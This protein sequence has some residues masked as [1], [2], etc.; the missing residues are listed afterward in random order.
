MSQIKNP[1][2]ASSRNGSHTFMIANISKTSKIKPNLR[3]KGDDTTEKQKQANHPSKI[4]PF[5]LNDDLFL[6][7][8][9]KKNEIL[10]KYQSEAG[11]EIKDFAIENAHEETSQLRHSSEK[12]STHSGEKS[13]E[14][15]SKLTDTSGIKTQTKNMPSSL[16]EFEEKIEKAVFLS[17]TPCQVVFENRSYF[18]QS[19][20]RDV[21]DEAEKQ[22]SSFLKMV[23]E[24]QGNDNFVAHGT[25]TYLRVMKSKEVQAQ[26]PESKDQG[27]Q[28][29]EFSLMNDKEET[30]ES[31]NEEKVK[32][33]FSSVEGELE[34][35]LASPFATVPINHKF[36]K[37]HG[38]LH[39][40]K[41]KEKEKVRNLKKSGKE[42]QKHNRATTQDSLSYL[43]YTKIQKDVTSEASFSKLPSGIK[44]SEEKSKTKDYRGLMA[45]QNKTKKG[46]MTKKNDDGSNTV[47][48]KQSNHQALRSELIDEEI[49]HFKDVVLKQNRKQIV[50]K[51]VWAAKQ[52]PRLK[53]ILLLIE[54]CVHVNYQKNQFLLYRVP[55]VTK[56]YRQ[57]RSINF[58]ATKPKVED[59]TEF[60]KKLMTFE[61]SLTEG[62]PINSIAI[63]PSNPDLIACGYGKNDLNEADKSGYLL[64]WTP[65]NP[66]HPELAFK[67]ESA[68]LSCRFSTGNPYLLACGLLNGTVRV[69]DLRQR[70]GADK[71][72]MEGLKHFEAVWEVYWAP[73]G[74]DRSKGESLI[75]VSADGKVCEWELRK[76]LEPTELKSL[77]RL[78]TPS[79]KEV[80]GNSNFRLSCG[81]CIDF[82]SAD[83]NVYFVGTDEGVVHRCSK[84]Y[85]EQYLESY[86]GHSG[87]VYRVSVNSFLPEVFLTCSADWTCRVWHS[88]KKEEALVL[89]GLE[90][91]DEI[92]DAQ[93]N[94]R[95]S[96]SF[97]SVSRDGR[98]ELWDF[99]LK[100]LDP[101]EAKKS[102]SYARTSVVFSQA[103]PVLF[104]G[105]SHGQMEMFKVGV[106]DEKV[107][108]KAQVA[109]LKR[110][111]NFEGENNR[112]LSTL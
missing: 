55:D 49:N 91:N 3:F 79:A 61:Y 93:W 80:P 37:V 99:S 63:N 44:K 100:N 102:P 73:R 4:M 103:Y 22:K 50:G 38:I 87:S 89:K 24:K 86:F 108:P 32:Q 109:K 106:S 107:D 47:R 23:K 30:E 72:A 19:E 71:T 6:Q 75:S 52:S 42:D 68:V 60:L 31:K 84:S 95:C 69:F 46:E 40:D 36:I 85:K 20:N 66:K 39:S 34:E 57:R 9:R 74:K 90:L 56:I 29:F 98:L 58:T 25:Q 13:S 48:S 41:E 59:K 94:P 92:V 15:P 11:I 104:T 83:S 2:V 51:I 14:K 78:P 17:E 26:E 110:M 62:L 77:N 43:N 28:V 7:L 16:G 88:K 112:V 70:D 81:L 101:I 65:K 64:L 45:S 111:L 105:N 96:T 1:S 67:T 53:S 8:A 33:I 27:A 76:N 35:R 5:P 97:A 18:V 10:E 82:H 12:N 54:K 21:L